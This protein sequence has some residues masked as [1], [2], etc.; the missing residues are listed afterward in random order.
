MIGG[1]HA[2]ILVGVNA[3][4]DEG[5]LEWF[6]HWHANPDYNDNHYGDWSEYSCV[7]NVPVDGMWHTVRLEWDGADTLK[8]RLDGADVCSQIRT[9]SITLSRGDQQSYRLYVEQ[10]PDPGRPTYT[11]QIRRFRVG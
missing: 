9:H 11:I 6:Q 4:A 10:F 8:Y 3:R 7:S 2:N 1:V 5:Q